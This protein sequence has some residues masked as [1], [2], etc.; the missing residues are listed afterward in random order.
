MN[1]FNGRLAKPLTAWCCERGQRD[2]VEICVEC[3]QSLV[4]WASVRRGDTCPDEGCPHY[5]TPHSHPGEFEHEY[6]LQP[7]KNILAQMLTPT[8]LDKLAT[9]NALD[10]FLGIDRKKETPPL[11]VGRCEYAQDV[12]MPHARCSDGQC[13]YKKFGRMPGS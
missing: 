13:L 12:A 6:L 2:G 4:D 11:C 10:E 1:L 7:A 9:A 3:R 8:Q 5:G